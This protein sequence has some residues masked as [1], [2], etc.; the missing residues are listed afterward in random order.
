[1]H[2]LYIERKH[3]KRIC[4]YRVDFCK[5]DLSGLWLY[6]KESFSYRS[7]QSTRFSKRYK[8]SRTMTRLS[9]RENR[10]RS[11]NLSSRLFISSFPSFSSVKIDRLWDGSAT[12]DEETEI[13]GRRDV[14]LSV[15]TLVLAEYNRLYRGSNNVRIY[16]WIYRSN[17]P[18]RICI[19]INFYRLDKLINFR[20]LWN[21][22]ATT[23]DQYLA[24]LKISCTK[25]DDIGECVFIVLERKK[26]KKLSWPY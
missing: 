9:G 17:V 20:R 19:F 10:K 14:T 13:G 26:K 21:C 15:L 25:F 24:K 16:Y 23:F 22:P 6:G 12:A 8:T 2:I 7:R 18:R 11:C 3:M 4:K 1:M 5:L